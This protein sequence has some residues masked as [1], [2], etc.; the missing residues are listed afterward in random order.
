MCGQ[1]WEE[2]GRIRCKSSLEADSRG[3]L[4]GKQDTE[5]TGAMILHLIC[6]VKR[7]SR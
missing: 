7:G 1:V 6:G 4:N 2:M 5:D 3:V